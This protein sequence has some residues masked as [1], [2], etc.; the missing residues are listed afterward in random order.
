MADIRAVLEASKCLKGVGDILR[1]R[2]GA[3]D[4]LSGALHDRRAACPPYTF[5]RAPKLSEA[6]WA[7]QDPIRKRA[8]ETW[9]NRQRRNSAKTAF[10]NARHLI[11]HYLR[12]IVAVEIWELGR[13]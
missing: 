7:P 6:P 12:Y 3:V 5:F 2:Q 4:L 10:L 13:I 9:R 1:P 11:Q 8:G